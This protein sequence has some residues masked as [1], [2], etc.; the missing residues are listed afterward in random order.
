[1]AEPVGRE[2]YLVRGEHVFVKTLV[3]RCHNFVPIFYS[4]YFQ[5]NFLLMAVQFHKHAH[6]S[7]M[8]RRDF[9]LELLPRH[10]FVPGNPTGSVHPIEL[11]DNNQETM[12]LLVRELL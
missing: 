9:T 4:N 12:L 5:K 2:I 11:I 1:M 3:R 6:E 10:V 8:V 7:H